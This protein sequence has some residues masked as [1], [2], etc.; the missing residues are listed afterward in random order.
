MSGELARHFRRRWPAWLMVVWSY[1]PV[2][3]FRPGT[4]NADTKLYLGEDPWGL[5]S[6]SVFA[7][8][9]SQF[10]GFIP[11]Q[12]IAYIWPSGP[13]YFLLDAVGS[14]QWL[15]QRLWVGTIFLA[16]SVGVV[17]LMRHLSFSTG[18]ALAASAIFCFS[19][20]V[21]SYQSRTSSMLLPWAAVAWLTY[22]TDRGM[23]ERTWLWPALIAA[24]VATVGS[25]NA[26]ATLL[27]LPAPVLLAMH[28][29]LVDRRHRIATMF[30]VRTAVLTVGA[31]LW[32]I[33]MLAIQSRHGADV[34]TYTETLESVSSTSN[35][36][37]VV[38]GMGY[39][40]NYAGLDST[41]MTT[42]ARSLIDSPIALV[43]TTIVPVAAIFTLAAVRHRLRA[44][45]L[46]WILVGVVLAV[47]V[48]P[49][50]DSAPLF[51]SLAN[52]PTSTISL[53]LRSST[54]A[55]PVLLLGIAFGIAVLC[56]SPLRSRRFSVSRSMRFA[57]VALVVVASAPSRLTD[58][59]IDPSIEREEI[60]STWRQL[61][62]YL[63]DPDISHDRV[64]QLP[65]QEFGAYSWGV[66]IDPALPAVTDAALLTR[67]L[68][69]LGNEAVMNLVWA[70]DEALREGRLN[71]SAL[72]TLSRILSTTT[73]LFPADL[74]NDRYATPTQDLVLAANDLSN[75]PALGTTAIGDHRYIPQPTVAQIR[76]HSGTTLLLGDGKGIVDAAVAEVIGDGAV[77][78]AGDITDPMLPVIGG[79]L[80][81]I[82][83][84]DTNTEHAQHW[85]SSLD[86]LGFPEDREG[87]LVNLGTDTG[88]IRMRIFSK[89]RDDDKTWFDQRGPVRAR[90]SSYG[91]P[92]SYRPEHRPFAAIDGD[93]G[94][95]WT[96]SH[97]F[98]P[99]APVLVVNA[100]EPV[101]QI[102]L[103]QPAGDMNRT[104]GAVS[105]SVDGGPWN[106]VI[107][108]Q[109][110][111]NDGQQIALTEPGTSFALRIDTVER[112]RAPR[113]GEELSG[114]GF[115]EVD[116]G[117]G[118]TR[119]IGTLPSRG[120]ELATNETDLSYVMTRLVPPLGR[121]TRSVI[122]TQWAR[123]FIVP[124]ERVFTIAARLDTDS[125]LDGSIDD[126]IV[127]FTE[128]SPL[129]IDGE[130]VALTAR[131]DQSTGTVTLVAENIVLTAG[132]HE[133]SVETDGRGLDQVIIT[134]GQ[135]STPPT[136]PVAR[137][138]ESGLV[139]NTIV[140]EPCPSG[141]WLVFGQGFNTGWRAS[142]DTALLSEP[143]PLEGGSHGWWIEPTD[144][145]HTVRLE[146]TPQRILNRA[147]LI[148]AFFVVAIIALIAWSLLRRDRSDPNLNPNPNP[149]PTPSGRVRATW[150]PVVRA[151]IAT[152]ATVA[153]F[154]ALFPPVTA[155]IAGLVAATLLATGTRTS[156]WS[157]RWRHVSLLAAIVFMVAMSSSLWRVLANDPPLDFDWVDI[158]AGSHRTILAALSVMACAALFA[159]Q[160]PATSTHDPDTST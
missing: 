104:I 158:T 91:P 89:Q 86:N 82:I 8:D 28:T 31:N 16:A 110:S 52:D 36:F 154:A 159:T 49:L 87:Q 63:N 56:D 2:V 50:D 7:W 97:G 59:V 102:S 90:A 94:T 48:H 77:L 58:G 105:V 38:R 88:D 119:E 76:Q 12:S 147:W 84:T 103:L 108:D 3:A 37:E 18:A 146:F 132:G 71:N 93:P 143:T 139:K 148:S 145:A 136:T 45:A 26:T 44:V 111:R 67:D 66:T 156:I 51:S 151:V 106:Q 109:R 54:R 121:S 130:P 122:E 74:D 60:A 114:V 112:L 33:T 20:Y 157:S 135:P 57:L 70:V 47:G 160:H 15:T 128:N 13:F 1:V 120:L 99:L 65:G 64:L 32:W 81:H 117:L 24:T 79:R 138:V 80:N 27:I 140:T 40:L 21:L 35:A 41:P 69:P 100:E 123:Q 53:A 11:H 34:L 39:W 101:A 46:W 124:N 115:A 150:A 149:N 133:V 30:A 55:I 129:S 22:F 72:A 5:I 134:T 10:A 118:P 107:L 14:P 78:L 142:S 131:T 137:I 19:P 155:V 153:T 4:L 96:V 126:L 43:A 42:A 29:L 68:V 144:S 6:R 152:F 85:R 92:L 61:D 95:A 17:V 141:C 98:E 25:V 23:R 125:I 9:S 75:E 113:P 62:R 73:V 83:V 127:R 116:T